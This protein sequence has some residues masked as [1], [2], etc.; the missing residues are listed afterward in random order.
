MDNVTLPPTVKLDWFAAS[1]GIASAAMTDDSRRLLVDH[2]TIM[3]RVCKLDPFQYLA[4]SPESKAIFHEAARLLQAE[5]AGAIA[6][7]IASAVDEADN[8]KE[9]DPQAVLDARIG[10][11][12]SA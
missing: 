10:T 9:D 12:P 1:L 5:N 4:L 8:H 6:Q 11:L 2:A 7:A 3:L